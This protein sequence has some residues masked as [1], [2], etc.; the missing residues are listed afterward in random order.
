MKTTD[1]KELTTIY[2]DV[3]QNSSGYEDV[4]EESKKATTE[5][6]KLVPDADLRDDIIDC[7]GMSL[8]LHQRQGFIKGFQYA[9]KLFLEAQGTILTGVY[10]N[11]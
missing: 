2:F 5:L 6:E 4:E 8:E 9:A 1:F 7:F 3:S 11:E 10:G